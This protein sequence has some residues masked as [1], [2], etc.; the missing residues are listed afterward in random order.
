MTLVA[1][2][3]DSSTKARQGRAKFRARCNLA[4]LGPVP[5]Q[6]CV[7]AGYGSFMGDPLASYTY[8]SSLYRVCTFSSSI[9]RF[10]LLTVDMNAEEFRKA[11]HAAIEE[12][13]INP[14]TQPF[15]TQS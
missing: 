11:A 7:P 4:S 15:Q 5:A 1:V 10:P 6:V 9:F 8:E 12:S 13:M 2:V 3:S 14:G